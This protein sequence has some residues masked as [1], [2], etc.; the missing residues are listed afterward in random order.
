MCYKYVCLRWRNCEILKYINMQI[1]CTY[2]NIY[3][4]LYAINIWKL[5]CNYARIKLKSRKIDIAQIRFAITSVRHWRY[6]FRTIHTVFIECDIYNFNEIVQ[7]EAICIARIAI[8]T[9]GNARVT[10]LNGNRPMI[11]ISNVHRRV[12]FVFDWPLLFIGIPLPLVWACPFIVRFH[13]IFEPNPLS[14]SHTPFRSSSDLF[15]SLE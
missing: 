1:H 14:T 15:D 12:Y 10:T 8:F 13:L 6:I 11:F 7:R 2:G 4:L 3:C 5:T 9:G